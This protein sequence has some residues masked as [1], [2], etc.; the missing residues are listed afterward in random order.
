MDVQLLSNYIVFT[1][2]IEN[3]GEFSPTSNDHLTTHICL[4]KTP[5]SI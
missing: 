3:K 5:D 1:Q 2:P 4:C